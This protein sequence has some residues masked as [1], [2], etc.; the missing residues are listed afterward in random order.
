MLEKIE[1]LVREPVLFVLE[2]EQANVLIAKALL[3]QMS[4]TVEHPI[5]IEYRGDFTAH[6]YS[7]PPVNI[8]LHSK[9]HWGVRSPT[10]IAMG[11][12]RVSPV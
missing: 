3:Y 6:C 10:R 4:G 8:F 9:S 7:S 11:S 5:Q 12:T 1:E 2:D